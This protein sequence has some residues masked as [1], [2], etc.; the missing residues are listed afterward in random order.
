MDG[1][2]LPPCL[3][4]ICHICAS[5]SKPLIETKIPLQPL[6]LWLLLRL[7]FAAYVGTLDLFVDAKAATFSQPCMTLT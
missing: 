2:K 3:V 5:T 6:V 7:F 1:F 4:P